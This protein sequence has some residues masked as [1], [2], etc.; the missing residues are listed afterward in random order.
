MNTEK[1]VLSLSTSSS[2]SEALR[3][4]DNEDRPTRAC[5]LL[6]DFMART[7]LTPQRLAVL[8]D[9]ERSTMYRLLS[10]ERLTTR[11]VFIRI[12]IVLKLTLDETQNLLKSGQRAELYALVRRDA[13]VIFS[14]AH[15]YTLAATEET[16]LRKG[17]ASLFERM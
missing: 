6:I 11:N 12:A 1:V 7:N 9:V 4:I 3:V 10:G 2:A 13:L 16:L 5:D 15:D 8:V 17:E 14:L